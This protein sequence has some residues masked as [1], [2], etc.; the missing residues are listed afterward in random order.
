MG[1]LIRSSLAA[2]DFN[3]NIH[4]K[5]KTSAGGKDMYKMKVRYNYKL[6]S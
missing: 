4:R 2:L 5:V 6:L 3:F 1:M